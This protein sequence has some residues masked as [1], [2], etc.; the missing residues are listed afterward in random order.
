MVRSRELQ[1]AVVLVAVFGLAACGSNQPGQ[2]AATS[3]QP[4]AMAT[5]PASGK[6]YQATLALQGQPEVTAD[7]KNIVVTVHVTNTGSGTFGSETQPNNVNLGAHSIDSAGKVVDNDL[8]RGHLPQVASGDTITAT[9]LMA[10]DQLLNKRAEILPV[11]ENVGWFDNWGTKPLIV[12]P[13]EA[14][15]SPATGKVC[16]TAGKP[17]SVAPGQQ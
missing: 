17:L 6:H 5:A 3:A 14:C 11:Q 16:D 1:F 9:I 7:G 13:F 12:G 10:T 4:S 15:S 8:S 2:S